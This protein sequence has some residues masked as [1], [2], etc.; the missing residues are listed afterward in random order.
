MAAW[1]KN[2]NPMTRWEQTA[3]CSSARI[4]PILDAALILVVSIC[5][6]CVRIILPIA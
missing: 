1:L 2:R 3:Q 6:V 5:V 4:L